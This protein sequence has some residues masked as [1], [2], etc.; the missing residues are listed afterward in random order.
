MASSP[1]SLVVHGRHALASGDLR[2]AEAA[3]DERLRSVGG[4]VQALEL[5]ALLLENDDDVRCGARG[6]CEE[7]ELDRRGRGGRIAIDENRWPAPP[8]AAPF[9]LQLPQPAHRHFGGIR[10]LSCPGA[11]SVRCTAGAAASGPCR[12]TRVAS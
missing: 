7:E 5:H 3:A 1:D 4:D 8:G 12:D 2:R 10:Q 9:E 11:S 6:G